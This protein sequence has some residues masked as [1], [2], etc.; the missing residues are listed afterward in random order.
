MSIF[1][2]GDLAKSIKRS[3]SDWPD[4]LVPLVRAR[5]FPQV[6]EQKW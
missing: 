5:T 3:A 6:S 4:D 1:V 2:D